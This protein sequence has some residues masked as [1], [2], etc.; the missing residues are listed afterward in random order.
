LIGTC[1]IRDPFNLT[2]FFFL[3]GGIILAFIQRVHVIDRSNLTAITYLGFGFPISELWI[4]L[5]ITLKECSLVG[6]INVKVEEGESLEGDKGYF[7]II[8]SEGGSISLS[9]F[10][11]YDNAQDKSDEIKSFLWSSESYF[12]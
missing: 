11:S 7:L 5:P 2:I 4:S 6:R 12:D 3:I 9:T 8:V 1:G 10:T